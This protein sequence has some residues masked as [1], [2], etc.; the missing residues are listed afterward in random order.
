MRTGRAAGALALSVAAL[1]AVPAGS[2]AQTAC[3]VSDP[4]DRFIVSGDTTVTPDD[5]VGDL[6]VLDGDVKLIGPVSGDVF[7]ASGDVIVRGCVGGDVTA[8]TGKLTLLRGAN[9]GGDLIYSDERPLIGPGAEV[10]GD[11]REENW[12]DLGDLPWGWISAVALWIAMTVSL[13]VSGTALA[14]IFPGAADAITREARSQ[15]WLAVAMGLA[16]V[17]GLPLLSGLA[18]VTLLGIPLSIVIGFAFIPLAWLGYLIASFILGRIVTNEGV[19]PILAFLA[20]LGILRALALIPIA[21]ALVWIP[22]VIFGLGA[23][24][25]AALPELG[26]SGPAKVA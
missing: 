26:R 6:T 8:I 4:G 22:A 10:G 1:L 5:P 21:G 2:A 11:V 23:L 3:G 7:V 14:G 13:L 15:P 19:H 24:I 16:A 12:D 17:I 18:F 20:G 9:V 25:V